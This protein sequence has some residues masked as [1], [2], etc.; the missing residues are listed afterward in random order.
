MHAGALRDHRFGSCDRLSIR[1]TFTSRLDLF[2]NPLLDRATSRNDFD[3]RDLRKR[4]MSIYLA[5]NPGLKK[6]LLPRP[7]RRGDF[8]DIQPLLTTEDACLVSYPWI[9]FAVVPSQQLHLPLVATTPI[10]F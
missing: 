7:G 10:G 2:A 6:I 5:I 1:K 8:R 9:G 3:L 4:P